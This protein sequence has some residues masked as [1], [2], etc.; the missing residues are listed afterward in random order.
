MNYIRNN[1]E[2]YNVDFYF[3]FEK[4]IKYLSNWAK[5]EICPISSFLGGVIA[6]EAIKFS[7]KYKLIHQWLYCDFSQLVENLELNQGK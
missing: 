1:I 2:I 5:I 7:G 4:T 3:I 6:Q